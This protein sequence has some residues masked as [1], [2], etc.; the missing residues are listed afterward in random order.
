MELK[1][2][3]LEDIK[4]AIYFL[5]NHF[6]VAEEAAG[7][8]ELQDVP[9]PPVIPGRL[10][11]G[12]AIEPEVT[13]IHRE[14]AVIEEYR[15]NGRRYMVKV[16]P[17]VGKPYYLLDRDGDGNLESRMSDIYN[18]MVVPQWVIFSW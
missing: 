3:F 16:T 12:E 1:Q 2:V 17:N 5:M 18:D 6:V 15:I 10:E 9:E 14:D 4:L 7:E 11:S 13:I 8:K